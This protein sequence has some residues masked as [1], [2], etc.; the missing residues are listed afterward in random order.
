MKRFTN[1]LVGTGALAL[2]ACSGSDEGSNT[3]AANAAAENVAANVIFDDANSFGNVDGAAPAGAEEAEDN[4]MATTRSAPAAQ[5]PAARRPN[6]APKAAPAPPAKQPKQTTPRPAP[7][8][9]PSPPPK[10][11]CLPEHRAAGHC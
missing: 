4:T 6:A 8:P 1:M 3:T 2:A 7:R 9:E 10:A 5:A 11:E